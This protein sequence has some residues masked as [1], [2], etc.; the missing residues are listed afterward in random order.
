MS[1]TLAG[2]PG[3]GLGTFVGLVV[4]SLIG[5]HGGQGRD[6]RRLTVAGDPEC[7]EC[8]IELAHLATLGDATDTVGVL[9]NAAGRECMVG[10]LSTGEFVLS[11]VAGGG[12]LA[13]YD[14][15]GKP[16][17][18]IGRRGAGP[19]EFR[20][21][22]RVAVGSGDSLYVLDDANS[23]IQVVS[24]AGA[25]AR[26]F[27]TRDRFRS[28][29]LL[30]DDRLLLFRLPKSR[31]DR[32]FHGFDRDGR[33]VMSF[34]APQQPD[35]ALDLENWLVSRA[36]RGR[37]WTASHWSY[38]LR[39]WSAPDSLDLTV[40]R[41]ADWF[42]SPSVFPAEVYRTAPPPPMLL[43]AWEDDSGRLWTYTA[44]ADR[45]WRP[46]MGMRVTPE[47]QEKTFDTI[48]EVID[49]P[50]GRLLASHRYPTRL[51]P[52]CGNALMYTVIELPDGELRVRV[53]EPRLIR[54]GNAR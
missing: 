22:L 34:G 2:R 44:V 50:S 16:V 29:T 11:G 4:C 33:Q 30:P 32:L 12:F 6:E 9:P 8:R 42:P 28:F 19:G 21:P 23:R 39:R 54:A 17:R 52:V 14:A 24:A 47:W 31:T 43:H 51:A 27:P 40:I 53:L 49:L 5:C 35:T 41:R 3:V 36:P 18:T 1:G 7:R 10:R 13:V 45:E 25:Y 48:I 38:E 26:V 46:G 15:T 37:F 20:S